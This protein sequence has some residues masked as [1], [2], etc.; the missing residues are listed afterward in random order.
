MGN[1]GGCEGNYRISAVVKDAAGNASALSANGYVLND[2][3]L[4][5]DAIRIINHVDGASVCR[6]LTAEA[7]VNLD[8][9]TVVFS[10]DGTTVATESTAPYT[11]DWNTESTSNGLHSLRATATDGAAAQNTIFLEIANTGGDCDNL[12]SV[13]FDGAFGPAPYFET[14]P[15]EMSGV[16]DSNPFVWEGATWNGELRG[17]HGGIDDAVFSALMNT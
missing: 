15:S 16:L 10:L 9:A 4:S 8:S 7:A 3:G 2:G 6:C 14:G 5:S 17:D 13:S 1:C 11:C 12:L